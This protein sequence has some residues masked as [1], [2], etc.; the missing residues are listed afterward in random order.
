MGENAP[1]EV[2]AVFATLVPGFPSPKRG[3]GLPP[4]PLPPTKGS[5]SS[6]VFHDANPGPYDIQPVLPPQSG[7]KPPSDEPMKYYLDVL[8]DAMVS[9]VIQPGNLVVILS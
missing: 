3:L 4:S 8:L 2:D 6:T 5:V 9:Q 7:E 1:E